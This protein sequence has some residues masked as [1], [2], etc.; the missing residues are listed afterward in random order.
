MLSQ[1]IALE[2]GARREIECVPAFSIRN[3]QNIPDTGKGNPIFQ[4]VEK[5]MGAM[6]DFRPT[7]A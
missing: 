2:G 1:D 3:S 7:T 4:A 6:P 5:I